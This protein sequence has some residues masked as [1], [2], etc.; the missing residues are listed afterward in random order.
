MSLWGFLIKPQMYNLYLVFFLVLIMPIDFDIKQKV[1]R[2]KGL[3][4]IGPHNKDIVSIIFGS[5]LGDAHAEKRLKGIGTRIS[6]FQ[7][8][9]HV[10][11]I[12]YL[13][14]IFSDSGYCNTKLPVI[15]NRLG[16]KGKLRKIVQFSTWTYTSFNWIHNLWYV[17]NIKRVPESIG[18]YLTP[19]ALAI[20]IMDDGAKVSKG[21]K[22]C[23]NSF[24]YSDC[25]ILI[26]VLNE[27][28][29]LKASIQSTGSKDQ[30]VI[31]IWKESMNDLRNIVS[32]YIIS[33]MKYKIY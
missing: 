28:F 2:I 23:T 30:Y 4:R 17:N 21:L 5:L 22:L 15:G 11:Y 13:H 7:E 14:K 18:Q 6:F 20:W 31:Y 10:E 3:Y 25:L 24:I 19:L 29:N 33:E 16:N 9:S 1:S 27:N 32:P 26:R 8:S 12:F